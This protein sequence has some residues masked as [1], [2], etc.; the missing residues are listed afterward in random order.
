MSVIFLDFIVKDGEIFRLKCAD[1]SVFCCEHDII[2]RFS[3]DIFHEFRKERRSYPD[4]VLTSERNYSHTAISSV[5]QVELS[6]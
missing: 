5:C 4:R 6:D 3:T 2:E 1:K